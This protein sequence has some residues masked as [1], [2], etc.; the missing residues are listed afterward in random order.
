MCLCTSEIR[1][2]IISI[3]CIVL[4]LLSAL[5]L[6]KIAVT[7]DVG[8][9]MP[10]L[11]NGS[12]IMA[13]YVQSSVILVH[14]FTYIILLLGSKYKNKLMSI[15]T[16]IISSLQI[17]VIIILAIYLIYA[18]TT[19]SLLML[20]PVFIVLT[21]VMYI[22]VVVIQFY[23][24]PAMK[25]GIRT[26]PQFIG[27]NQIH[28]NQ[29]H[30]QQMFQIECQRFPMTSDSQRSFKYHPNEYHHEAMNE[31]QIPMAGQYLSL[32]NDFWEWKHKGQTNV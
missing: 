20:I 11:Y 2:R 9:D 27:I 13:L 8:Y 23:R 31:Q 29:N 32:N 10:I 25:Q 17:I 26:Q 15:P 3:I 28:L 16:L 1:I 5:N 30:P 24:E 19:L 12:Y 7:G 6:V 4:T 14:L 22:L 21:W 18:G